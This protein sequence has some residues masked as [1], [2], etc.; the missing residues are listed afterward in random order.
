MKRILHRLGMSAVEQEVLR[1]RL[2][3]LCGERTAMFM[4]IETTGFSRTYDSVYLIGLL[5]EDG[6]GFVMEQLLA[7]SLQEE[8]DLL[9]LATERFQDFACGITYNGDNFDLPFLKERGQRLRLG[10]WPT[11]ETSVDLLRQYRPYA[12][13]F[14]WPNMKLKTLERSLGICREDIFDGGQLIEVYHEYVRTGDPR[15]E[16]VLLLHNYEDIL[17]I[18]QLLCIEEMWQRWQQCRVVGAVLSERQLTVEVD[19]PWPMSVEVTRGPWRISLQVGEV[20]GSIAW[21]PET[22]C[23]RYYLP[24][25]KDYYYLPDTE[26]I[27]HK[28]L[29]DHIPR[30]LRKQA[31]APVCYLSRQGEFF[32]GWP[33]EETGLRRYRRDCRDKNVYFECRELADWLSGQPEEILTMWFRGFQQSKRKE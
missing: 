1:E 15:L 32:P 29:A 22:D 26:E 18:P 5:Y 6:E 9:E 14:A 19:Q 27:V 8:P 21:E 30:A 24:N 7:E 12:K 4:D 23:L 16:K 25:Y 11:V 28:S 20:V 31:T 17:N 10:A 33:G 3:M 2:G 13:F